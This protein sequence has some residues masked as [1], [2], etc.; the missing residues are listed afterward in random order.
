[1][2]NSAACLIAFEVSSPALARPITLA[3]EAW[4]WSRKDEKSLALKG[5]RTAPTTLPPFEVTYL[6]VSASSEWPKA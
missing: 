4:A 6:P 5:W 2:P 3:R 1:M